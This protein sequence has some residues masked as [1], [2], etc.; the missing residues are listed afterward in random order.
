ML[1]IDF[2]PL[3]NSVRR[4]NKISP[5]AIKPGHCNQLGSGSVLAD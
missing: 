3:T 2:L 4:A 1:A 5:V